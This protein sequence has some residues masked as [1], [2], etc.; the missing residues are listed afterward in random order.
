MH[1]NRVA[2]VTASD[3]ELVDTMRCIDLH[4]V[5]E[6]RLAADL[7]HWLRPQMRFLGNAGPEPPASMTTF[8]SPPSTNCLKGA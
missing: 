1:T 6:Y 5:P 7:D 4:N 2:F 8:I 3:D